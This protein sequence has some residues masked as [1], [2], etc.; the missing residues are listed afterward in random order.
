MSTC[1]DVTVNPTPSPTVYSTEI[2][3]VVKEK[4]DIKRFV[5]S[6]GVAVLLL[7]AVIF[8]FKRKCCAGKTEGETDLEMMVKI[9]SC[10]TQP[11][12]WAAL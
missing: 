11:R 8:C 1:Y 12:T 9:Q 5:G 10:K 3:A 6:A 4:L 7:C 2:S